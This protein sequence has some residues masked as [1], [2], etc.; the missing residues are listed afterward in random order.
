M[1][2]FQA[3]PIIIASTLYLFAK[4]RRRY[5][6]SALNFFCV[7]FYLY[8]KKEQ[9]EIQVSISTDTTGQK[10]KYLGTLI[11][12]HKRLTVGANSSWNLR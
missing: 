1:E 10:Q 12:N 2:S 4:L 6:N 8:H 3:S 11:H 9:K 7:P 5:G